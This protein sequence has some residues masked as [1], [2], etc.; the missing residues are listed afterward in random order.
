MS[1]E[2]YFQFPRIELKSSHIEFEQKV[3]QFLSNKLIIEKTH[4]LYIS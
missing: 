1:G 4:L 2:V 3:R